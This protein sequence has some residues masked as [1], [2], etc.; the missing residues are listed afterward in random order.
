MAAIDE[1]ETFRTALEPIPPRVAF[2][3]SLRGKCD[4]VVLFVTNRAALTRRFGA[5]KR[6]I[7]PAGAIWVAWPKRASKVATGMT[8][9][10]VREVALPQGLVD[11]KVCAID[12]IWSGLR[13]VWRVENRTS[14]NAPDISA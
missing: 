8:E 10:L 1:P 2:R 12:E 13:V 4:V 14:P 7:Y 9:D 5:A 6:T 11:N 3:A